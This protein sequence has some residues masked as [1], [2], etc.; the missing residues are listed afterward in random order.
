MSPCQPQRA[1]A[2]HSA[3]QEVDSAAHAVSLVLVIHD[4]PVVQE[5]LQE[6]TH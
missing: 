1:G 6:F 5:T 3:H 2:E 4:S